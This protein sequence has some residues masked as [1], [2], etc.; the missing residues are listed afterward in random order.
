MEVGVAYQG[1]EDSTGAPTGEAEEG[2]IK[3]GEV[4]D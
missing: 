3:T 1:R 4:E 2:A